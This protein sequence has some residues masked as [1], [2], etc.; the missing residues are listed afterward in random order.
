M[1]FK[2]FGNKNVKY[3]YVNLN[4]KL[5]IYIFKKYERTK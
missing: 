3:K 2:N 1:M 5:K 4:D